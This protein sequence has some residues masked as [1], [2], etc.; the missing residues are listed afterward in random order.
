[1]PWRWLLRFRPAARDKTSGV[2]PHASTVAI[3][4]GAFRSWHG[5]IHLVEAIQAL[6]GRG[7]HDIGAMFV[8]DGPE[9]AW[10]EGGA[11]ELGLLP[12]GLEMLGERTDV[13]ALLGDLD[14]LM[15]T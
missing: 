15:L 8:G 13:P 6:R 9:R 1:L 7:R 2:R 12:G 10:L 11:A 4:S 3:F 14:A 5:A